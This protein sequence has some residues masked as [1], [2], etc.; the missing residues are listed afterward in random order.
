MPTRE[1]MIGKIYEVIADKTKS[2]WCLVK[3]K[4]KLYYAGTFNDIWYKM[5]ILWNKTE[6]RGENDVKIHHIVVWEIDWRIS[7]F[8]NENYVDDYDFSTDDF[9][10]EYEEIFDNIFE[11]IWH[12]VMIW[13]VL[14]RRQFIQPIKYWREKDWHGICNHWWLKREPIENQA[15]D[16]I[17][18][19]YNLIHNDTNTTSSPIDG[20]QQ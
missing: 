17:T 12:P 15:D 13:D 8:K 9:D 4:E 16:C 14:E 7:R 2:L 10:P 19:I 1:E 11:I 3:L 5:K 18:F 20:V 6:R